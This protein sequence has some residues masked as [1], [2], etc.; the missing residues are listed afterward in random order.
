MLDRVHDPMT[1]N[2]AIPD[3][4]ILGSLGISER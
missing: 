2:G 4:R 3:D 1:S